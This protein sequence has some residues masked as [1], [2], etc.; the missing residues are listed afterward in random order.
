MT[1]AWVHSSLLAW[2][3]YLFVPR[4]SIEYWQMSGLLTLLTGVVRVSVSFWTHHSTVIQSNFKWRCICLRLL[5]IRGGGIPAHPLLIM[6]PV[7]FGGWWN[8]A[9][10]TL[11]CPFLRILCDFGCPPFS[12][13]WNS[14]LDIVFSASSLETF[15]SRL[16][17]IHLFSSHSPLPLTL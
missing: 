12:D 11:C 1:T 3:D 7:M 17:T 6:M 9:L 16:K 13:L 8:T 5:T 2:D 14:L 4:R 15:R 10:F